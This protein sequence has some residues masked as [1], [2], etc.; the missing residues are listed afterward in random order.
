M[1]MAALIVVVAG[2][3]WLTAVALLMALRPDICL[4][5]IERMTAALERSSRRLQWTE[6]GLRLLAGAALVVRAPASKA[7]LAFEVF[8]GLLL[9]A[10]LAILALPIRRH[11]AYGAWLSTWLSAGMIRLLSPV[12]A[13]A[14]PALI[15]A[16]I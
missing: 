6:Q 7:P 1:Q 9:L 5:L 15:Y 13:L 2:G 8:G 3:L 10:S 16:A 4:A 12:P 14:G 11:A